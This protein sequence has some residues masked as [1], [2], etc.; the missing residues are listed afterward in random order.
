MRISSAF[1]SAVRFSSSLTNGIISIG[2]INAVS[3]DE[4]TSCT[5][6][7]TIPLE[8]MRTGMTQRPERCVMKSSCRNFSIPLSRIISSIFLRIRPARLLLAR[9]ISLSS[10][11]AESMMQ[12]S[13]SIEATSGSRRSGKLC[14]GGLIAP[15]M[16][17]SSRGA[18]CLAKTA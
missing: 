17:T 14:R 10:L 2:S 1:S 4:E 12:P 11:D 3:P 18:S 6:P 8:S 9:R 15:S 5:T 16:G 7:L 13:A